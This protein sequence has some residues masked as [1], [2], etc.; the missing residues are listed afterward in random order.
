MAVLRKHLHG[1]I[2]V[3]ELQ[4][5]DNQMM[6]KVQTSVALRQEQS[7]HSLTVLL[8]VI[9]QVEHEFSEDGGWGLVRS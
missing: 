5:A 9:P 7:G 2:A 3:G 4:R 6:V 1:F 8:G